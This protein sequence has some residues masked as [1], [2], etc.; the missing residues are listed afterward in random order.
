MRLY[1]EFNPD[2]VYQFSMWLQGYDLFSLGPYPCAV[3]TTHSQSK[4]LVEIMHITNPIVEEDIFHIEMD[5]GYYYTDI[6]VQG[7]PI[8]IFLYEEA[9]NYPPVQHG[10]WVKFF[11]H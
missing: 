7:K 5:A 2:L 9:T 3:R 4:I 6:F 8:G 10:D 1:N 11:G